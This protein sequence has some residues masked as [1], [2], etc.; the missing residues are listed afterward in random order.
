MS[1]AKIG[2]TLRQRTQ[3]LPQVRFLTAAV[4]A[5]CAFLFAQAAIIVK[6]EEC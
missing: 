2:V 1:Q 3:G 4:V 6:V 5:V